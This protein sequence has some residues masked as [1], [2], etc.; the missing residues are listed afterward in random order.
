VANKNIRG[1]TIE[2]G[3]DTSKLGKALESSEKKSRALQ[4]E[5]REIQNALRFDPTNVDLLNQKQTVLTQNISE[6]SNK[7]EIL[8]EAERQVI[9]QFERGEVA[10]EQVRA[11]R[12]E[13]LQTENQLA[14]M[15]S[16]LEETTQLLNDLASGVHDVAE[17]TDEYKKKLAEAN[18]AVEDF[19]GKASEMFDTLKTGALALGASAVAV[20]GYAVNLADEF[21]QAY[22]KIQIQTGATAEE[23][24][25]LETSIDNIYKSNLGESLEDIAVSM[26]TVKTQTNLTGQELEDATSTALLMRD[27]FGFEVDESIRGVNA[28]MEQFGLTAIEAYDL[29]AQGAQKGLNSNGDLMDVINEY[30][31]HFSQLGFDSTEMFNILKAGAD[32]GAF[33]VDKVGDAF[34][35]FG[36]RV[37]DESDAT[38]TAF[39]QLG[40][41]ADQLTKDFA[42]GGDKGAK[43]F[44]EV[45]EALAKLEDPLLQNQVGVALFGSM[46]EDLGAKAVTALVDYGDEFNT[47]GETL[48]VINEKSGSLSDSL[49]SL[50][51]T[52]ETDV[53]KPL[54]EELKPV[55]E[56]VVDYV[57]ENAPAIKDVLRKVIDAVGGFIKLI[58]DNKD[59]IMTAIV[60][61]GGGLLM[62]NVFSI[63]S[64]VVTVITT[65]FSAI[66]AGVPIMKA[67]NLVMSANPIGIIITAIGALVAG[68]IYLWNTSDEF[69]EFFINLWDNIKKYVGVVIDAIV[70]FFSACWDTIKGVIN[71]FVE[72][73]KGVF[74]FLKKIVSTYIEIWVT[75]F[76]TVFNVI[77]T[78]V[79]S[80]KDFFVKAFTTIRDFVSNVVES[81]KNFFTGMWNAIKTGV[82]TAWDFIVG[83][84]SKVAGWFNDTVIQPV[85]N[86]F[87]G[88]WDGLK[89]GAK[90]AW[91]GIKSI[92]SKVASF[93]G[94]IFSTAWNKVKSIFSA[95][96]KIFDGIKDGI[97]NAFTTVVNAIIKGINKVVSIPFNGINW[98][99]GKIKNVDIFGL[100]PFDW[101]KTINVP[102]IPLL[103]RGGVLKKGQVGLLE[104]NGAEAVVPLEKETGWINRIAQKM[105][106]LQDVKPVYS[107]E[108]LASKMDEMIHTMKAIKSTIVLDTGVLVGETITQIDEQLSNSYTL[109]ERRV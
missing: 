74:E 99:L 103:Y 82:Q 27:A 107:N 39:E 60:A 55:I 37:K 57:K 35:E 49:G 72:F 15:D 59:A 43:A 86:F 18:E 6:T 85:K 1:I 48:D 98:A 46:W 36:I 97:V 28:L 21:D 32:S 23:M 77:M 8:K 52:F 22:H 63:V 58:I 19:K 29:I 78:I 94:N 17:N 31:V 91:E 44:I 81:I 56:D 5:L 42:T 76:T 14:S 69:R 92:F 34:K 11:L 87:T 33:S 65:L 102:Q 106:E 84:F 53:I 93:F 47:T 40:L 79:T 88:M 62:W 95:G 26:A 101:I 38:K 2:I 73:F 89:N 105:N 96:G 66:K 108:A 90:N 24:E 54:G 104:G 7:L 80:V 45:N 51:K 9:A 20:G 71:A 109:R 3:G 41:N 61:I 100:K 10:E 83:I 25:S 68:F 12:R 4:V 13:I 50:K 30:S 64:S 70:G 75:I 67:L 16:E